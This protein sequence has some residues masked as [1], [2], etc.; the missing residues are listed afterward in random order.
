MIRRLIVWW[1]A[2]TNLIRNVS[3]AI[4]GALIASGI[5]DE[6][7]GK[8]VLAGLMVLLAGLAS[9]LIERTKEGHVKEVQEL[10]N[11]TVE[12]VK[13]D[14]YFGPK[15]KSALVKRMRRTR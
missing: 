11:A 4:V 14:G 9:Y 15:T 7:G 12:P 10:I 2:R 8:E 5:I 1:I 3:V 13:V 6:A